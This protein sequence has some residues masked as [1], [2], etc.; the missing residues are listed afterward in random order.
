MVA[1]QFIEQ[2]YTRELP[3][4][5]DL[6]R[7]LSGRIR[8]ALDSASTGGLALEFPGQLV[9]AVSLAR[10][11]PLG[12]V[13]PIVMGTIGETL[14]ALKDKPP[15]LEELKQLV[16]ASAARLGASHQL[17]A[18]LTA[19]LPDLLM[20]IIAGARDCGDAMVGKAP[21]SQYAIWTTGKE[22]IVGSIAPYEQ[23][24]DQYLLWLDLNETSQALPHSPKK[25]IGQQAIR[26]LMCLVKNLG[27]VRSAGELYREAWDAA[28]DGVGASHID[29][30]EQ[31]LTK[32]NRFTNRKFRKYL[33]KGEGKG[34]G[35]RESF[36]DRYFLF[37]RLR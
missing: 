33:L 19:H 13:T 32:L 5:D 15:H 8:T 10:A 9:E 16:A 20:D 26:V 37:K 6:W 3:Y 11:A 25:R 35:L 14:W 30:I 1:E 7:V 4:F 17:N 2:H 24:R 36:A 22:C 18:C 27:V 34:Y 23:K 29:A 28:T 21:P 12:L 31:Q